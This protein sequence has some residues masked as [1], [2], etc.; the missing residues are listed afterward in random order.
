MWS[1]CKVINNKEYEVNNIQN[2]TF[3]AENGMPNLRLL[4]T[5]IGSRC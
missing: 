2:S 3:Y 4:L 5:N 1:K